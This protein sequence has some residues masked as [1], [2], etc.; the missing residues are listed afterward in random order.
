MDSGNFACHSITN[1]I[2]LYDDDLRTTSVSILI[3]IHFVGPLFVM[4]YPWS[5]IIKT[6]LTLC[7]NYMTESV[8]AVANL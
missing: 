1:N 6:L 4:P 7:Q 3:F 5:K 2:V 8:W